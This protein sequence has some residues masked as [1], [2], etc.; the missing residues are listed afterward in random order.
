MECAFDRVSGLAQ[1]VP[2]PGYVF[3]TGILTQGIRQMRERMPQC[4]ALCFAMKANPFLV[5]ALEEQVDRFEVCSPGEYE[6]CHARGISPDKIIVSGVNKTRESMERILSLCDGQGIFTIESPL[7]YEILSALAAE[8]KLTLRVLIRLSSGNQFGV[9]QE[10]FREILEKVLKDP[11]LY[12]L[13]IH[14]FSGTQKKLKKIQKELAMLEDFGSS[15]K[16]DYGLSG[17]ELEYG[18][19]LSVAYFEGDKTPSAQEQLTELNDLLKQITAFD[20]IG[21]EMGRFIASACGFF[22]SKVIDIKTTE[23]VNYVILD[24]GIHQL[25]YFGQMMG[26]KLPA[27]HQIPR[28]EGSETYVL[29]G[30]LCTVN[31]VMVRDVP[32]RPLAVGDYLVFGNCGAYSMTEGSALFLS[33]ELPA[34]YTHEENGFYRCLRPC[35][36]THLFNTL[37]E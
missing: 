17:M 29:C 23:G 14:Y 33:R 21:I 26:M 15:L 30:S 22:I 20:R 37:A 8:K 36:D 31:D 7:H 6:I 34:V 10:S 1:A 27:I 25:H 11:H 19:G 12:F 2:S 5:E 13:G 32:L 18:P 9:D 3:D 4:L 35:S 24:G 16:R 28:R